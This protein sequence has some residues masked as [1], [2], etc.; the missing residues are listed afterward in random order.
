MDQAS[1]DRLI[2]SVTET[3]QAKMTQQFTQLSEEV[4]NKLEN[5]DNK[6]DGETKVGNKETHDP[7]EF[8]SKYDPDSAGVELLRKM[9]G[10]KGQRRRE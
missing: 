9:M 2:Q 3:V 7:E 1:L 6:G 8:E 5:L 10:K 4:K